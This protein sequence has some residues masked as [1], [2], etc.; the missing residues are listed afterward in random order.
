MQF[1]HGTAPKPTF[2]QIHQ[3][4]FGFNSDLAESAKAPA[5]ASRKLLAD[6]A[7]DETVRAHVYQGLNYSIHW[8][9]KLLVDAA[10]DKT[11]RAA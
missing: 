7:H 8:L 11:V 6:A 3:A 2:S 5:P 10:H 4:I 9:C 1:F